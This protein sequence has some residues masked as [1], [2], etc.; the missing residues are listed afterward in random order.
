MEEWERAGIK[1]KIKINSTSKI[2]K[3]IE[4]RKN[5]IE[6]GIRAE[7][8]GV[9]PHS[10]GLNFSRS[11]EDRKPRANLNVSRIKERINILKKEI[12]RNIIN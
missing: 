12:Q 2:K 3:I 10:K 11:A 1:G 5:R 9:N 4:I 7:N 8:L 6:K